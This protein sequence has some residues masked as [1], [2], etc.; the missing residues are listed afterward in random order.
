VFEQGPTIGGKLNHIEHDGCSFETGPTLVTMPFV[1]EN[2]FAS[3]GMKM[4]DMLVLDRVDPA[5]QYRWSD[6]SRLDLPFDLDAI[7]AAIDELAPG[8]G[9]AVRQYLNDARELYELTKDIFIFSEFDGFLELVKPRNASLLRHLPKLRLGATLHDVHRKRFRDPR[10]SRW[11]LALGIHA[12]ACTP[13]PKL[14][15]RRLVTVAHTFI[16]ARACG[17]SSMFTALSLVLSSLTG[18]SSMQITSYRTQ[19]YI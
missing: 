9:A 16:Q 8:D 17:A 13:L 10:G 3:V 15:L 18:Q 2:F 14:S 7:P 19:T 6:G 5:C 4:S 12:E 1:F 11:A